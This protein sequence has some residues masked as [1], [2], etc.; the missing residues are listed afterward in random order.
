MTVSLGA[1]LSSGWNAAAVAS[2]FSRSAVPHFGP[3][4]ASTCWT[5]I[6]NR[7]TCACAGMVNISISSAAAHV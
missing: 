2:M 3:R 7:E 4:V 5:S 6:G 1:A